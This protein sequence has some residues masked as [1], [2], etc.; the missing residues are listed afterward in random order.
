MPKKF[1]WDAA[2]RRFISRNYG[3][4][5]ALALTSQFDETFRPPEADFLIGP[6]SE[7]LEAYENQ[8]A[9][10][11]DP[12]AGFRWVAIGLVAL[13]IWSVVGGIWQGWR[14]RKT[15]FEA[16]QKLLAVHGKLSIVRDEIAS[17]NYNAN[18]MKERIS[19]LEKEGVYVPSIIYSLLNLPTRR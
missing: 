19:S 17:G 7:L 3:P 12:I 6:V 9:L 10:D 8:R 13:F 14:V 5:K 2:L 15:I 4:D 1:D 11:R 18:I 16:G